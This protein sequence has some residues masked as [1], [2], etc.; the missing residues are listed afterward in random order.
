M[1]TAPANHVLAEA[2]LRGGMTSG[3]G[4]EKEC[5]LRWDDYVEVIPGTRIMQP[6]TVVLQARAKSL[7]GRGAG[8]GWAKCRYGIEIVKYK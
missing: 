1:I 3:G 8:P 4:S 7:R 6:R 2:T 5:V